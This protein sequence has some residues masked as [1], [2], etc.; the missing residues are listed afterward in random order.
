M[1]CGDVKASFAPSTGAAAPPT[2]LSARLHP[3]PGYRSPAFI[4]TRKGAFAIVATT[5]SM[6]ALGLF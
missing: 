1:V 3:G 5:G 4:L 2:D 6:M